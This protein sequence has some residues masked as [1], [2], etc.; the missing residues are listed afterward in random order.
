MMTADGGVVVKAAK[1]QPVS[2]VVLFENKAGKMGYRAR[3]LAGQSTTL[4]PPAAGQ[5]PSVQSELVRTLVR[6]GLYQKEAE[7]MVETWRDSWFEE[8]TR[9]FYIVPHAS[10]DAILPLDI[11]PK[12]SAVARVFVGRIELIAPSVVAEV[13]EALVTRDRA[14]IA[15]YGRFLRPILARITG[16]GPVTDPAMQ[17]SLQFAYESASPPRGACQ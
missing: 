7:A 11:T 17:R 14:T 15:K 8:G 13:K 3:S 12:P 16:P 9:L 1:G 5:K 2:D 6:H 10:I 4:A